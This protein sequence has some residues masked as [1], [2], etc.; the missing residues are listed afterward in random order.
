MTEPVTLAADDVVVPA[1]DPPV[2]LATDTGVIT[3]NENIATVLWGE[4]LPKLATQ[5]VVMT[6]PLQV[7]APA[8]ADTARAPLTV[9][10]PDDD[11]PT[12]RRG[13]QGR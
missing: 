9:T 8:N 3:V 10:G 12:P 2:E 1:A 5:G 13:H 4:P 6:L 11:P 7:Y